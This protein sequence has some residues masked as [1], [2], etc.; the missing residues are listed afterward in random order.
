[1]TRWIVVAGLLAALGCTSKKKAPE[2]QVYPEGTAEAAFVTMHERF[3]AKDGAGSWALFSS[4][5]RQGMA[6]RMRSLR[7]QP[8]RLA[9]ELDEVPAD[10]ATRSDEDLYQLLLSG[11]TMQKKLAAGF[12]RITAGFEPEPGTYEIRYDDPRRGACAQS[13]I[14][15]DGAWKAQRGPVCP[16]SKVTE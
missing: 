2:P 11:A 3:R 10:L 13:F 15:E 6:T 7:E 12:P 16:G 8:E 5:M 1:M 9:K 4:E 14:K